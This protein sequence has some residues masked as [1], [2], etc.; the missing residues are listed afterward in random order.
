MTSGVRLMTTRSATL[1]LLFILAASMLW[2]TSGT[3]QAFAPAD[4]TPMML[5]PVRMILGGIAGCALLF[6]NQPDIIVNSLGIVYAL[7]TGLS[8]STYAIVSK[9]LL[10]NHHLFAD[11][12]LVF[13]LSAAA[14][15][16]ISR[17]QSFL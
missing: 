5:G 14:L 6:L 11:L 8:Y 4:A 15:I 9:R 7:C 3:S 17:G 1:A 13:L 10:E 16:I 12:S 2:V